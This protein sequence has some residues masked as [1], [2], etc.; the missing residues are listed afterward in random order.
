MKLTLARSKTLGLLG[1]ALTLASGA[2]VAC[3]S[4][5]GGGASGGG[6]SNNGGNVGNAGAVG[7]AGGPSGAGSSGASNA[8]GAGGVGTAG[9]SATG[10]GSTGGANTG[11]ASNAGASNGMAGSNSAGSGGAAATCPTACGANS[12]CE[13]A[14]KTCVCNP[15]FVS[16]GGTC[17]AAPVGDPTTHTQADVCSQWKAGHVVTE[18]KPMTATVTECTAG[19]LKP[20]AITDTLVRINM[21]RWLEGLG[22]VSDDAQYDADAQ[23]CA[24]LES[25]WDFKSADSPHKPTSAAKCYTAN[26][27]ATAGQ[28][29]IAWGSGTPAQSIDQYMEDNGNETTLGHRRWVL[30]PPLNPIG[31]GY[32]EKGGQYGN[33][34]CLR[35]F[36]SKG[37]G[38]KPNWNAV[39]PAGFAPIEMAKYKQW[40]FEGSL[41]GIAKATASVLRVDDNMNLPVTQQALSQGYGQDT[42]SFD[43]DG[44]TAEAGKTYR[45]TIS[46]LTAGNVVYDVKPVTCN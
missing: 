14:T 20:G 2:L 37:T 39:P 30:N 23:A 18:A 5:D 41:A 1:S 13:A 40:S 7:N 27:A 36:A 21:F 22:P 31:I 9:G 28:S 4:S 16:Q 38:P 45:V 44:W 8:A 29:N 17:T 12:K 11:G 43:P 6:A 34:S 46:G 26:G 15:G 42:M 3:S 35:V 33:A 32:W 25:W 19:S 10:G 24:N